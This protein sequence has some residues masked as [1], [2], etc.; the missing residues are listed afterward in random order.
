MFSVMFT[1]LPKS[2]YYHYNPR[3]HP[4]LA[5]FTRPMFTLNLESSNPPSQIKIKHCFGYTVPPKK[6]YLRQRLE[7]W[8]CLIC[9]DECTT[10]TWCCGAN[11]H[12]ECFSI[13][14]NKYRYECPQKCGRP[15]H[16][17]LKE[18]LRKKK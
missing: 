12:H 14:I 4:L 5:R 18:V 11:I 3:P 13:W 17:T 7:P 1:I 6:L 10:G 15:L 16:V 8:G 2:R 9:Q